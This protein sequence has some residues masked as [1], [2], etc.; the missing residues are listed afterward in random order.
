MISCEDKSLCCGCGACENIC[1]VACIHM[2]PDDEGFLYPEIDKDLCINCQ[3]CE[4][5]CPCIH[6]AA[7]TP[8]QQAGYV[9]RN[10]NKE[11]LAESTSGG[12]FS[13]I[14]LPILK[15]GGVVY[16]AAFDENW[17][18][19]HVGVTDEQDLR[20]FR[21][22]KYVQSS[23]D[24]VH[25]QIKHDL[26]M[27]KWVCFGG[28][29]CQT[30]GLIRFLG[31]NPEKLIIVDVVCRGVPSPMIWKKYLAMRGG[32]D[33]VISACFRDKSPYGYE[34]SSM[35][36]HTNDK[37]TS[38]VGGIDSDQYLRA[39]FSGICSRPSCY[40]CRFKKRYR[41]SDFTLWEC[42][43]A[44]KYFKGHR[45]NPG[46]TKMLVQSDKGNQWMNH[47]K[48][49]ADCVAA[50][51]NDLID[52][53]DMMLHS[54]SEKDDRASFLQDAETIPIEALFD[55]YFPVTRKNRI[56]HRVRI[57]FAVL[58]VSEWMKSVAKRSLR[59]IRKDRTY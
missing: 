11:I 57:L 15:M 4:A 55:K 6:P 59:L 52:D 20:I 48:K 2:T 45:R 50:E 42:F 46:A 40:S 8:K 38:Y 22:S 43:N 37:A 9:V 17:V 47:V 16:G 54:A 12:A 49:H 25:K 35:S 7:E 10:K 58:G 13:A 44:S 1:P 31:C 29:P 56:E 41:V 27:G 28:C 23:V 51:P 34:Y 5:V 24:N 53:G 26:D 39:F 21:S 30:E 18:V 14:A 19:H 32:R 36:I 3:K 33:T